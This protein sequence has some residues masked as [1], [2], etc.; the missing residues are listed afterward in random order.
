MARRCMRFPKSPQ[1]SAFA[2]LAGFTLLE[3]LIAL[4]LLGLVVSMIYGSFF[5]ISQGGQQITREMEQRQDL[6][7][8]V[9][10]IAGELQGV[11]YL[12]GW[13][14]KGGSGLVLEADQASQFPSSRISMHTAISSRFFEQVGPS[15]SGADVRADPGIHEVGYRIE[16]SP[17]GNGFRLFRREDY[18]LD[19]RMT[20]GGMEVELMDEIAYFRVDAYSDGSD[21]FNPWQPDWDS[22]TTGIGVRLPRALRVS[23]GQ[24]KAPA[25]NMAGQPVA[26]EGGLPP[27]EEV[28]LEV[29]LSVPPLENRLPIPGAGGG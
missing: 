13:G 28:S 19:D 5:Q 4:A 27:M 1:K 7:L 26:W 24:F 9:A 18:Y 14:S 6:R 20:D 2:P 11:R 8:L 3:A 23:I 12:P 17:S 22:S 21:A 29:N 10:M 25:E 15:P 16:A